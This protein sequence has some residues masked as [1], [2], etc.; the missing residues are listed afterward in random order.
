MKKFKIILVSIFIAI[1][2]LSDLLISQSN[3][4]EGK[5]SYALGA[6]NVKNGTSFFFNKTSFSELLH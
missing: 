4:E 2:F 1:L 6:F 3:F 5:E